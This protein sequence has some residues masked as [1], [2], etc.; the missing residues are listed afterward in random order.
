MRTKRSEIYAKFFLEMRKIKLEEKT[1]FV[2]KNFEKRNLLRRVLGVVGGG[3]KVF[4]NF[5]VALLNPGKTPSC[6]NAKK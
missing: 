1:I 6:D 3:E 2:M 4:Y 5:I